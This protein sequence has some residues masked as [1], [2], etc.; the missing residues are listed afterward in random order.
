[1]LERQYNFLDLANWIVPLGWIFLARRHF[2]S[3]VVLAGLLL[4]FF[5]VNH[6]GIVCEGARVLEGP[7]TRSRPIYF[8]GFWPSLALAAYLGYLLLESQGLLWTLLV[9]GSLGA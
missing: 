2:A 7:S 9:T 4:A 3:G 5:A 6:R 1:V 8:P